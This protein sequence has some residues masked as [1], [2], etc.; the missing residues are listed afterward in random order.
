VTAYSS[1]CHP[2]ALT[3]K[4]LLVG[5]TPGNCRRRMPDPEWLFRPLLSPSHDMN[6]YSE[7][8]KNLYCHF[9]VIVS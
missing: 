2:F 3:C 8:L 7:L 9:P 6:A 1:L 5:S 4:C